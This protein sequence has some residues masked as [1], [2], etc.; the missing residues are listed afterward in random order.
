MPRQ[1]EELHLVLGDLGSLCHRLWESQRYTALAALERRHPAT[2]GGLG[3]AVC[4]FACV[5][6]MT[7]TI[8]ETE[9]SLLRALMAGATW[10]GARIRSHRMAALASCPYYGGPPETE[11]HV[12]WECPRRQAQRAAWLPLV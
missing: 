11:V 8:T 2:F 12:L 6:G 4:R 9:L 1:L 5:H 10:M 3:A 7:V